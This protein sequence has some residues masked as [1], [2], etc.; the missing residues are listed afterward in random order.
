MNP[1]GGRLR[2]GW[3]IIFF[4]VIWFPFLWNGSSAEEVNLIYNGDFETPASQNLPPGWAM[5]GPAA[6][7]D[8]ANFTLDSASPRR[9]KYCFR[10][11]HPAGTNG[12][13]VSSPAYALQPK[14][15]KVYSITFFARTSKPGR[16]VFGV[17]AYESL[18]PFRDAPTPGFFS[19]DVSQ[20]WGSFSFEIKEGIDFFADR[21][22]YLLLTFKATT[23]L[24]EDKTLWIDEV[25]VMEKDYPLEGRLIDEMTL[26]HEPLQH[27]LQPG[28]SLSMTVDVRKRLR[29][30]N[31]M[32]S[33]ISSHR[34]AG[35]TGH[36][37]NS[38][39]QYTLSPALE[40]AIRDLHLP[41]TRFYGLGDERFSLEEA[42]DKAAEFCRRVGIPQ[43]QTVLEFEPQ[44]A[45]SKLAPEIWEQGVSHS[46]RKGYAFRYWEIANEPENAVLKSKR[47]AAYLSPDEYVDQVKKVSSAIRKVQP[48]AQVGL[49][50]SETPSWG[51]YVLSKAAGHYD[52]VTGHFYAVSQ[53]H[54]RKFE[55]AVLTDN[56][57][58]L[59]KIIRTNDLIRAYNPGKAV[60]QIDTEWGMHSGGPNNEP[61]DFVTRNANIFGVL[62]RAVR[63]IYYARE[64]ILRGAGSWS[65]LSNLEA[66]GFAVLSPQAP[67]AR[68]LSYWLYYYFNRHLGES[69]LD[70]QGAAPYYIPAAGDDPFT[71]SG[72][73]PGPLTPVLATL[74]KDGKNLYLIMA[75]G[76]WGKGIPCRVNILNHPFSQAQA[77]LLTHHDP[78][79][80]PFLEKKED[81]V[82]RLPLSL[83]QQEIRCTIPPHSVVFITV[84]GG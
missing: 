2:R 75:N 30:V 1:L 62:H 5:W 23:D 25:V 21:S 33:G 7:Q 65:L 48:K 11:H 60:Y 59:E 66:P 12:Y 42:I 76:S 37:F 16:S 9:G 26:A 41:M 35:H 51:N 13:I 79:G 32:V 45:R 34:V 29:P 40:Q 15:R 67:E 14:K 20:Q 10:I 24:M 80:N 47:R 39:G 17:A 27:R 70:I 28:P 50:I 54:R 18:N 63:L 31:P 57:K 46:V 4:L 6:Y 69:V 36:P 68:S 56:F 61:A 64:G 73:F 19:I 3:L 81:A 83:I 84:R 49:A 72:E 52:F 38:Q 58:T 78:D 43:S 53:A 82:S 44:D 71:R 55:A 74:S 22:R 8:P 77:V